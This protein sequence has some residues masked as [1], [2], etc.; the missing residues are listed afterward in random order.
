MITQLLSSK[1]ESDIIAALQFFPIAT[2]FQVANVR[3]GLRKMLP[4]VWGASPSVLKELIAA[5]RK[6]YF[7]TPNEPTFLPPNRVASNLVRLIQGATLAETTSFAELVPH[8]VGEG[9]FERRVLD[10]LWGYVTAADA[11]Y[12]NVGDGRGANRSD[13]ARC[14]FYRWLS[15]R[16]SPW[17]RRFWAEL[18]SWKSR[19]VWKSRIKRSIFLRCG[20]R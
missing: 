13:A 18:W 11:T 3:S 1:T 7:C 5:I 17:L 10:G 20:D 8:L 4:L 2:S 14:I 15:Q 12:S 16:R 19:F 6:L 9:L